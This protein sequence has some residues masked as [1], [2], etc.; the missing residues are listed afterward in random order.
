MCLKTK[1]RKAKK[2]LLKTIPK[3]GMK[4]YKE[5]KNRF[6]EWL[7]E[8]HGPIY[9]LKLDFIKAMT[10]A[11]KFGIIEGVDLVNEFKKEYICSTCKDQGEIHFTMKIWGND[12]FPMVKTCPECKGK[13]NIGGKKWTEKKEKK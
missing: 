2:E 7:D 5:A 11:F 8:H 4:V 10:E 9:E 1:D 3:N 6:Y 13:L 12:N